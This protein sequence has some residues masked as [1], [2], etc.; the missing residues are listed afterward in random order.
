MYQESR[1]VKQGTCYR[2]LMQ[3]GCLEEEE[4]VKEEFRT[5]HACRSC[6]T[7]PQFKQS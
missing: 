7:K 3:K 2:P 5:V 1:L 4:A 6:I